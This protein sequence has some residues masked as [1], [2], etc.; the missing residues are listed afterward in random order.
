[1]MKKSTSCPEFNK[2]SR[3]AGCNSPSVKCNAIHAQ[4]PLSPAHQPQ[5]IFPTELIEQIELYSS[6][7]AP[8][9]NILTCA[10]DPDGATA[11]CLETPI[12]EA[13]LEIHHEVPVGRWT[14]WTR[15]LRRRGAQR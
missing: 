4:Q 10:A 8:L 7:R 15:R 2:P 5:Q 14:M 9:V 3:L 6:M 1:M 11:P 13:T 12:E